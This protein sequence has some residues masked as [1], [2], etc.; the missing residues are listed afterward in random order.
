[1]LGVV[2][3]CFGLNYGLGGKLSGLVVGVVNDEVP[4]IS[5][6]YN[7]S[8]KTF[9]IKRFDCI[10]QKT[11]CVF[12]KNFDQ[13]TA[14]LV[15]IL[16]PEKFFKVCSIFFLYFLQQKFYETFEEA[17]KDAKETKIVGFIYFSENFTDALPI[18][19]DLG[20]EEDV[21][22][23]GI[24]QVFLDNS[25]SYIM[26]L[27]KKTLYDAYTNFIRDVMTDCERSG[28]AGGMP[29]V[30]EA[31]HG[32]IDFDLRVTMAAGFALS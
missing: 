32:T 21:T 9:E 20:V 7:S 24:V 5:D 14:K 29:I 18:F 8:L 11:S 25:N 16:L 19:N 6:C 15:R 12:I 13:D 3:M 4:S 10:V 31:S 2:L 26:T 27:I 17:Y 1:M 28:K 22:E 23:N 30:F